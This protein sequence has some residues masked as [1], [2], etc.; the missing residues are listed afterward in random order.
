MIIDTSAVIAIVNREPGHELL[1]DAMVAATEV[2]MGA[3][4][5]VEA[6]I[7]ALARW[8]HRGTTLLERVIQDQKIEII[9][10]TDQHALV[11]VDAFNRFGKGRHKAGLNLGDCHTYATAHVA[12]EPL[13][14]V[15]ND[16]THTDLKLVDLGP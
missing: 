9:S 5:H 15:G 1:A 14:Y 13:L 3:P 10:F 8:G 4:T 7:V 2:K 12:R 6:A 11:A 16:F